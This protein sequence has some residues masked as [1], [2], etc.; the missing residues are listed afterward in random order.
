VNASPRF[1]P[2]FTTAVLA[3]IVISGAA[4]YASADDFESD[5][6]DLAEGPRTL[7]SGH[8]QLEAG[9]TRSMTDDTRADAVGEGLLRFGLASRLELRLA[10][11]TWNELHV[12]QSPALAGRDD[13]GFGPTGFGG[14]VTLAR[15]DDSALGVVADVALPGGRGPFHEA[16][17]SLDLVLAGARELGRGELSANVSYL[18]EEGANG[19]GGVLSYERDW[20]ER[21]ASYGE[22]AVTDIDESVEHILDAGATLRVAPVTQLDARI[23][24]G[25]GDA[26]GLWLF[27]AG[28]TQRW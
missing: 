21:L 6:P 14:K 9:W 2:R 23:G 22:W 27:G 10:L 4:A 17:A 26:S 19:V 1:A 13:R 28:V 7:S 3:L 5:R 12:D 18:R 8:V 20:T 11:P 15:D 16:H 24:F 25:A